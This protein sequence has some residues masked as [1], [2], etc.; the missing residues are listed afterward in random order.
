MGQN[1]GWI[2]REELRRFMNNFLKS[3]WPAI[4]GVVGAVMPFM[5]PSINTYTSAHP[6][7]ALAVL[8]GVAVSL[9]Y[10]QSPIKPKQ[11]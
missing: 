8:L 1:L 11:P 9:Y 10:A 7:A 5:L 4:A 2:Q 3:H 6:H